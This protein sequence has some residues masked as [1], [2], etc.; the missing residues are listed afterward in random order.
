[1]GRLACLSF[2]QTTIGLTKFG[3]LSGQQVI[4]LLIYA[5]QLSDKHKN[6]ITS[7]RNAVVAGRNA[8]SPPSTIWPVKFRPISCGKARYRHNTSQ[9]TA[10]NDSKIALK[11][12][13]APYMFFNL[14]T[15]IKL[16]ALRFEFKPRI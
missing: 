13:S 11:R 10:I 5:V 1:M 14:M 15:S 3:C 2:A 12:I 16:E 7:P 6:I 9:I 4:K 8:T